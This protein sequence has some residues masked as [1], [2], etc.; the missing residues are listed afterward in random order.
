VKKQQREAVRSAESG[1]FV[2]LVGDANHPEIKAVSDA[3]HD[4]HIVVKDVIE[5]QKKKLPDKI[6]ILAQTTQNISIF[7]EVVLFCIEKCHE[8]KVF[9]TICDSTSTRQEMTQQLA[10]QVDLMIIVGGRNSANTNRLM[11][12]SRSIQPR[13]YLVEVADEIEP[14]MLNSSVLSI[15]ISAGASTPSWIIDQVVAKIRDL[16]E[17]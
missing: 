6:A 2:V 15:G 10:S 3:L 11:Y 17:N 4:N 1:Y 9:N 12:L 16:T 14:E 8:V 7:R 13:T 5:L